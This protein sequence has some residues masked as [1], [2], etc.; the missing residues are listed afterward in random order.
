MA[1]E[2]MQ[3]VKLSVKMTRN[4]LA[5]IAE[6]TLKVSMKLL[7]WIDESKLNWVV[8]SANPAAI[9][10]LEANPNRINCH[11]FSGNPAAIHLLEA[12]ANRINW[13]WLS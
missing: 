11:V 3:L 9:H 12:N 5:V 4:V 10:L 13:D 8:L 6:Y 2:P 1:L 7:D